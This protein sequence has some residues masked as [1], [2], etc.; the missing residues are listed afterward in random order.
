MMI[1]LHLCYI[2][3]P[4]SPHTARMVS[5]F[6]ERGHQ[7]YLIADRPARRTWPGVTLYDFDGWF[8]GRLPKMELL[9]WV[10]RARTIVHA[11]QPD[12]L[13][14][15][16]V[17]RG[18]WI[19]LGVR[20]HPLVLTAWGSDLLVQA[21][22]SPMHWMLSR[23]ALCQ[24]DLVLAPAAPV[25]QR[26]LALGA[27]A[28]RVRLI[29]WGVDTQTYCPGAAPDT[30]RE[31]LEVPKNALV[32]LSPRALAPIYNIDVILEAMIAVVREAPNA[33]LLI[34]EYNPR[35][36]YRNRIAGMIKRLGLGN[37]VRLIPSAETPAQMADLYRLAD[38]VVSVPSSEGLAL[39]V[40]EAMVCGV[41][42]VISNL[43]AFDG[44]VE[45]ERNGL[46]VPVRDVEAT[47]QAIVRLLKDTVLRQDMGKQNVQKVR[48]QASQA[49]WV[50][51]MEALYYEL[52]G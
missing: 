38:V 47:A 16:Q 29:P 14:A 50:E 18:G 24:A 11:L 15:H 48:E 13:H 7:V 17:D 5:P 42:V 1:P 45:P 20:Y 8:R 35:S 43:P 6:V 27:N 9:A 40:L 41:P 2:A 12:V 4:N 22:R 21:G 36:S 19:S 28:E 3:N 25:Y 39:T 51:H 31:Q 30:L 52:A 26:A 44:W 46:M 49:A 23:A 10:L 33:L 34:V 37:I 32:V